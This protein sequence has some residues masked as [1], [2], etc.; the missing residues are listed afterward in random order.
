MVIPCDLAFGSSHSFLNLAFNPERTSCISALL[1][2]SEIFPKFLIVLKPLSPYASFN[3][4]SDA[5]CS[6][7]PLIGSQSALSLLI[8]H[9]HFVGSN[10]KRTFELSELFRAKVQF[11]A[12]LKSLNAAFSRIFATV[13]ILSFGLLPTASAAAF[14]SGA[15]GFASAVTGFASSARFGSACFSSAASVFLQNLPS[16]PCEP[17][18]DIPSVF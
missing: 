14:S 15:F 13:S 8:F 17:F 16:T 4:I 18:P 5:P 6:N 11:S 7:I 1:A 10:L 2:N 12:G 3:P 9:S